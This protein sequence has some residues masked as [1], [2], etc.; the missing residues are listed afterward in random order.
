MK[1]A[2]LTLAIAL[3]VT[4]LTAC[5]TPTSIEQNSIEMTDQSSEFQQF[6]QSFIDGLWLESPTWALYSGFHQ[7][8]GVLKVPNEQARQATLDFV[9]KQSALLA[10]F[11]KNKLTPGLLT[12]YRLI[13]NL[14]GEMRWNIETFKSWQW[15]PTSYNV[16]GALLRS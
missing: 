8:D 12:D 16:S 15:D 9:S 7:Y 11:D 5:Q 1:K 2:A 14:I 13:E 10:H 6:S 3:S 4:G